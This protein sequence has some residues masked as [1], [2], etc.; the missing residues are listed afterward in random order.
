MGEKKD[1]L[2]SQRSIWYIDILIL[3][4]YTFF[5]QAI[6]AVTWQGWTDSLAGVKEYDLA[7]R[8]L[9]GSH[10]SEMTEIF[11]S[12][13]VFSGVVSSGHTVTLPHVGN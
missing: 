7:V 4:S 9:S 2:K 12:P 5:S 11:D 6:T 13:P 8:Q 10:D 1:E 3:V